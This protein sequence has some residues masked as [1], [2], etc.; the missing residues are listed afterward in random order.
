MAQ[1][2][3]ID[4][5][6]QTMPLFAADQDGAFDR[7]HPGVYRAF[8]EQA[9]AIRKAGFTHYSARTIICVMRFHSDVSMGPTSTFKIDNRVSPYLARRLVRDDRTFADFFEFRRSA[10]D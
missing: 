10:E 8:R 7:D 9:E 5:I 1:L 4:P 6:A 3:T 2:P